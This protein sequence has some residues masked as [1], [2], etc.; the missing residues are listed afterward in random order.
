M[1]QCHVSSAV[2]EEATG[3]DAVHDTD[4]RKTQCRSLTE[5]ATTEASGVDSGSLDIGQVPFIFCCFPGY[6]S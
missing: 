5:T 3:P 1:G 6:I 2:Q 4:D